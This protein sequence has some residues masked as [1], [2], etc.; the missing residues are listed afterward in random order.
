MHIILQVPA[1]MPGDVHACR[2]Q[3]THQL[4]GLSLLL[5]AVLSAALTP[6]LLTSCCSV[7]FFCPHSLALWL[8]P[9]ALCTACAA[10]F[11]VAA[12]RAEL[13]AA[14][15]QLD[16]ERKVH[17]S[18]KAAATARERDLEE[19]LGS[20]RCGGSS[21]WLSCKVLIMFCRSSNDC[22]SSSSTVQHVMLVF[23]A[24]KDDAPA[25]VQLAYVFQ[26]KNSCCAMPRCLLLNR[27]VPAAGA[28]RRWQPRS[29]RCRSL[30]AGAGTWRSS[31]RWQQ[32][33]R[34]A[35]RSR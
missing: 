35:C 19:Q 11:I 31:M 7:S 26:R 14:E 20:S 1:G 25:A 32:Q 24:R 17:A 4:P 3:A 10:L 33:R 23:L 21:G 29:A 13:S 2:V 6:I 34:H 28:V 30:Q 12:L 27:A 16:A 8:L 15:S 22:S 5:S 9:A 18:T